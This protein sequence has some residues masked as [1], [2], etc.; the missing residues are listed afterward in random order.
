MVI[1]VLNSES[2]N[3]ILFLIGNFDIDVY[4]KFIFIVVVFICVSNVNWVNWKGNNIK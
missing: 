3:I 4:V 1:Y 2:I